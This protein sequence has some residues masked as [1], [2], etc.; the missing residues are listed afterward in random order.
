MECIATRVVTI[1]GFTEESVHKYILKTFQNEQ[2]KV[3]D[4]KIQINSKPWIK[5]ILHIPINVAIVCLIFF[6]SAMSVLPD[7]L[8]ELYNLLI[9]RLILRYIKMRT[10]NKANLEILKSLNHLP[11]EISDQFTLLC[12][13]ASE[14]ILQ[15]K[16]IF[17]SQDLQDMG[18]VEDINGMGFATCCS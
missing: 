13:I 9:L 11:P 17:S 18:I 4:L 10:P 8:T 15:R 14:G 12:R 3:Y 5:N 2:E 7:T 6:H 16:I 1:K